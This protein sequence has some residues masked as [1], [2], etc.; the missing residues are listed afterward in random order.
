MEDKKESK[1]SIYDWEK[2]LQGTTT[3]TKDSDPNPEEK[4]KLPE[5]IKKPNGT[6]DYFL[7]PGE[8][9]DSEEDDLENISD[10]VFHEIVEKWKMKKS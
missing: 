3:P 9:Q 5:N 2:T 7:K 8:N 1:T 10:M 6:I 4:D